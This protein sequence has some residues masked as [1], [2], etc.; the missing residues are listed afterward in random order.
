V[1]E[2]LLSNSALFKVFLAFPQLKLNCD[3]IYGVLHISAG[4]HGRAH[5]LEHLISLR[6]SRSTA[7]HTPRCTP[8]VGVKSSDV[9]QNF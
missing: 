8:V 9:K 6:H 5:F 1:L 4:S 2:R 7:L 3:L